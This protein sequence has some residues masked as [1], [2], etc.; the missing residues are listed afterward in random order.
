MQTIPGDSPV[1]AVTTL[2]ETIEAQRQCDDKALEHFLRIAR[3]GKYPAASG[4]ERR[5]AKLAK[6]ILEHVPGLDDL[7]LDG[8]AEFAQYVKMFPQ[9]A[10]ELI[11][12]R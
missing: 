6:A 1:V 2:D 10:R 4:G 11:E 12:G 3:R 8:M 9:S 7:A 5:A